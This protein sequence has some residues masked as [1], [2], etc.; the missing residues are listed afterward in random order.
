MAS[1][2]PQDGFS[3]LKHRFSS[4]RRAC[5][6]EL[7]Q[8]SLGQSRGYSKVTL[9]PFW[10]RR[11]SN[12][13]SSWGVC[14]GLGQT[15]VHL[16]CILGSG[17]ANFGASPGPSRDAQQPGYQPPVVSE[18]VGLIFHTFWCLKGGLPGASGGPSWLDFGRILQP[19]W[20]I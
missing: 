8:H 3:D 19:I 2:W 17:S 4:R 16:E 5:F 7:L 14:G 15:G 13:G 18:L 20:L 9:K 6:V 10:T 12:L 11:G 1:S